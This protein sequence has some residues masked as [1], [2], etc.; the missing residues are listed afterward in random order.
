MKIPA[1]PWGGPYARPGTPSNANFPEP[2]PQAAGRDSCIRTD[3]F[4][5]SHRDQVHGVATHVIG[6][7]DL[8]VGRFRAK[9]QRYEDVRVPRQRL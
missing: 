2:P 1:Y 7:A 6:S 5:T 4:F 9:A 3:D 8:Q